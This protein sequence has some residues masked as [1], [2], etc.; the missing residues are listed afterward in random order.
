MYKYRYLI[1]KIKDSLILFLDKEVFQCLQY[2]SLKLLS[3][4]FAK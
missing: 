1:H 4:Q 3:R 2:I